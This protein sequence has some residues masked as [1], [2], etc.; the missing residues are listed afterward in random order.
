MKEIYE[1]PK[2]TLRKVV[3]ESSCMAASNPEKINTEVDAFNFK[4]NQ[5]D[6]GNSFAASGDKVFGT[7]WTVE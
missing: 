2:T 3:M 7:G 4:T 5:Q 1:S 6:D